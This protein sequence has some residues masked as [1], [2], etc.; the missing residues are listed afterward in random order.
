MKKENKFFCKIF[1]KLRP[2]E[3]LCVIYFFALSLLLVI[4]H[5][6]LENWP[7]YLLLNFFIIAIIAVMNWLHPK[8]NSHVFDFFYYWYP[9]LAFLFGFEQAARLNHILFL[10][11]FDPVILKFEKFIYGVHPTIWFSRHSYPWLTEIL[12]FFYFTYYL[13]FPILGAYFYAKKKINTFN[14]FLFASFIAYIS[15]FFIYFLFPIEGPYHTLIHLRAS[16]VDGYLFD[17]LVNLVQ[18]RGGVH[19]NALPSAHIATSV[20]VVI[21][22][23]KYARKVF[24]F[25]FPATIGLCVGAVYGWYHYAS[26]IFAGIIIGLLAYYPFYKLLYNWWNKKIYPLAYD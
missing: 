3:G 4:F 26:D 23:Y 16:R 22:A 18:A 10:Q 19:G 12:Q 7:V 20:I 8:L 17:F 25:L 9:I 5:R 1:Q 15:C 21:F 13:Q 2:V 24:Y 14:N 11:W 6:A